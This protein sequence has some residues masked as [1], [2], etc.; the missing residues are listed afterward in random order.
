MTRQ[1]V[2]I[3]GGKGTRLKAITGDRPK[4]LAEV[5]GRPLLEHQLRLCARHGVEDVVLLLGYGADQIT[6]FVGDG[7]RF[8]VKARYF[9]EETPLGTAGAVLAAKADL[10]PRFL[11]LY[12]DTM[13]D[14]DLGRL[15]S[16]HERRD[17]DIT[18]LVH[19]NDHPFDSD[20]VITDRQDRVLEFLRGSSA[21]ERAMR[22]LASAALYVFERDTLAETR[23]RE[24]I[25]DF[26]KHVFPEMLAAGK[27]IGAY[28]TAEYIKDAGT[29]DRLAHVNHDY[30]QGRVDPE[31]SGRRLPAVFLDRDGTLN[32]EID[33]VRDPDKLELLPGAAAA[34]RRLNR[35]GYV[36][37]VVTNQPFVARGDIS[38]D[39]LELIHARLE[40]ELAVGGAY[41]DA[42]YHC[43]HHPHAGYPGERP[44]LK[45]VCPCRKP[46]P[47]ML[48]TAA[49][50]YHLDLSRS[51]MIGDRAADVGAGRQAGAHTV[52]LL[53]ERDEL[54]RE[55]PDYVA[56]D[57]VEATSFILDIHPGMAAKA[58]A[59]LDAEGT[60]KDLYIG[61]LARSGK[62]AWASVFR[63]TIEAR[64]ERAF[65]IHLDDWLLSPA[66]RP[67]EGGVASRYDM[68]GAAAF[69]N[70]LRTL[71]T[72]TEVTFPRYDRRARRRRDEPGRTRFE[73]GMRIVVEGVVA[74]ALPASSPSMRLAVR[75]PEAIR[76]ARLFADYR[77]RGWDEATIEQVYRERLRDETPFVEASLDAADRTLD[78]AAA[79]PSN[80]AETADPHH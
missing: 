17:N 62:S 23:P 64:G 1:A 44:E 34:V 49:E 26:G 71:T 21:P 46:A 2:I 41:V 58:A 13:M 18:I 78:G 40:R 3:A 65:V 70:G 74:L 20:L 55:T 57:L 16:H 9:V 32:T 50:E 31:K 52:L 68:A 29:P 5:G 79:A 15:W 42:I 33:G 27:T 11:V 37:A 4:A 54:A 22:N 56:G 73:P 60:P 43:P 25:L 69:I 8:G 14:I 12:A 75:A 66:D 6:D 53:T 77:W 76:R 19:P 10:A 36:T 61:G 47:G 28:R 51:W 35:T 72:P 39:E 24:G 7:S 80:Q 45:I 59:I 67:A 38:E 30:A 48:M 63:E